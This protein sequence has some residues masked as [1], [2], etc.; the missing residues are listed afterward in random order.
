MKECDLYHA[1]Y[2]KL[3]KLEKNNEGEIL[4]IE[5][6]D[7]MAA[8]LFELAKTEYEEQLILKSQHYS[9]FYEHRNCKTNTNLYL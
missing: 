6:V 5:D 1:L 9:L 2:A 3:L 4:H 8:E 7:V